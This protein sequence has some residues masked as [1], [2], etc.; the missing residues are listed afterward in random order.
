VTRVAIVGTGGWGRQ[1]GRVFASRDDVEIVAVAGRDRQRTRT[2]AEQVGTRPYTDL[3]E[4]V[5]RERPDLVS[6]CLPN[7]GHF[8]PTMQLLQAGVAL[9]VEKPLVF[10]LAEADA[11]LAEA[12]RQRLFFAINFNHR[13]ARPV[14]LAADAVAR[15]DLGRL[16]FATWRFGGEAGAG[17]HP[18]RN[19]IETQCHGFDMLEHLAGPI[20]SVQ[21]EVSEDRGEGHSTV[22]I[23]LRFAGGA[24]GSLVGSYESSYA[25]PRA[26]TLELN[27]TDGR[28]SVEDTVRRFVANRA[29]S[30]TAEVWEA[31]YFNDVD[32][33]FHRTFDRHVDAVLSALRDGREPPIPASAGRRALELALASIHSA[34]TGRR[35]STP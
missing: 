11:L 7:E 29:G 3:D 34:E 35:V 4:M 17:T 10:D 26:H 12:Q 23:A 18:H 30:E 31:G 15:G 6:V 22:V 19:L 8:A 33:E 9:L 25:Y 28:V 21:A 27:G 5:R 24:L 13:Y 2:R 1:H 16:T 20:E 32:R 14:Q